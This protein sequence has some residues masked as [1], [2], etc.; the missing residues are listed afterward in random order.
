MPLVVYFLYNEFS[1]APLTSP[2]CMCGWC[3][4]SVIICHTLY[5][6]THAHTKKV[7][8]FSSS[9]STPSSHQLPSFQMGPEKEEEEEIANHQMEDGTFFLPLDQETEESTS[10][11]LFHR[12]FRT[13]PPRAFRL[14]QA[15]LSNR[16]SASSSTSSMQTTTHSLPYSALSLSLSLVGLPG[17]PP[18]PSATT[19]TAST[20]QGNHRR[21]SCVTSS[22]R[23]AW[24]S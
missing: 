21:R 24:L 8:S 6:S 23:S 9:S 5:P 19:A 11:P 1:L 10:W 18:L 15:A 4:R 2:E 12:S 20:I 14:E 17:S 3:S 7:S 16:P 13:S 22:A